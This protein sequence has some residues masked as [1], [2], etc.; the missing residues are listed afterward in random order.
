METPLSGPSY[1]FDVA[2]GPEEA[3][4]TL[5]EIESGAILDT[6]KLPLTHSMFQ[7]RVAAQDMWTTFLALD[8]E[9]PVPTIRGSFHPSH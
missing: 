3:S 2:I 4:L 8:S 9:T 5:L 6:R 1:Q 7:L